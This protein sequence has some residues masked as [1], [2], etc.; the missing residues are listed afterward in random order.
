MSKH[1]QEL[2]LYYAAGPGDVVTTFR[3]WLAGEDDPRQFACTYS[4]QF[5]DL[6]KRH[7]AEAL[8]CSSASTEDV[9]ETELFSV[10]NRPLRPKSWLARQI[11]GAARIWRDMI[12][13]RPSAAVIAEGTT[14]W[15][16]ILPLRWFGI[17]MIPTIHCVLQKP[18][19]DR[20]FARRLFE[21][22]ERAS[23]RRLASV[24]LTASEEIEAQI[25]PGQ[26][27]RR[28]LPTYRRQ[29][30]ESLLPATNK[31]CTFQLLYV[32][33][34]EEDKG[35]FDLLEALNG[36]RRDSNRDYRLDLCGDG[37]AVERVRRRAIDLGLGGVV[38]L[39]GHCDFERLQRFLNRSQALVVP[40]SSRFVEGFNQVIVEGVFAGRPV[41]ASSICPS[42]KLFGPAVQIIQPD[43]PSEIASAVRRLEEKP[44][45]YEAAVAAT[46]TEGSE[47]FS[48]R[49]SWLSQCERALADIGV[50]NNRSSEVVKALS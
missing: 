3:H 34:I 16:L 37:A 47:F 39:R 28:F 33:R 10:R 50:C 13:F 42:A 31:G 6:A 46:A 11:V 40:T 26:A 20:G 2:R 1:S 25:A 27:C 49:R 45:S 8:V 38:S 5:F 48:Q 9:E 43:S 14:L 7:E 4:S 29:R 44:G 23:L 12:Y 17:L 36:L 41:I 22:I 24:C 35:V 15:T 32:G 18:E 30:F 19:Q 21:A